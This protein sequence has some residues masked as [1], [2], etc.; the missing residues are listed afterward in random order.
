MDMST[1]ALPAI[2]GRA[3]EAEHNHPL[4]KEWKKAESFCRQKMINGTNFSD[5]LYQ[6]EMNE[7]R[8]NWANHPQYAAFLVWMRENQGGARKCK[9]GVFPE[10]FKFWLSGG[11][12]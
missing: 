6:R 5:W 7:Y 12:W 4:Y 9:A 3:S 1:A 8:N 11:R 2:S 10:N